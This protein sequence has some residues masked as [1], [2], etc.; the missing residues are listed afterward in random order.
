ML[1]ILLTRWSAFPVID[2]HPEQ[3]EGSFTYFHDQKGW[4]PG[5]ECLKTGSRGK[6]LGPKQIGMGKTS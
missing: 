1:I 2:S 4:N 3:D 6:Y 5:L